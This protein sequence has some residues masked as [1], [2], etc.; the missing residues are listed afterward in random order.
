MLDY[1]VVGAGL[2]GAVFAQQ[3]AERGKKALVIEKRP[4]IG[5]N[6]YT[7]DVEGIHVLFYEIR[8]RLFLLSCRKF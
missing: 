8:V 7:E 1:L 3:A 4:H 5:G 6:V 2:Y